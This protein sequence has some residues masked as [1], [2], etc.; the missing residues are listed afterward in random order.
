MEKVSDE[1][2]RQKEVKAFDEARTGVKGIVD[3]GS[4]TVPRMFIRPKDELSKE[5]E[6]PCV[7]DLQIP[8]ISLQGIDNKD[9]CDEIVKQV[10]YASEKWGFFQVVDHGIPFQVLEKMLQGNKM[11]HELDVEVKKVFYSRD[12]MKSVSYG[13]N[14]DLYNSRVANW[15]DTVA[16]VNSY[17][18]FFDPS[19]IPKLCRDAMMDYIEQILKLSDILLELLSMGLG[20]E[21][22]YLKEEMECNKGW[23]LVNHYYPPCPAP[24]LT[25][26]TSK[27]SDPAFLTILLQDQIGGLQVLYENQ[28]VNVNPIPD[29]FVVNIGDILQMISNDKLKSTYHRVTANLVGPRISTAFFLEGDQSSTKLYRPIKELVSEDHPCAYKDFTLRDFDTQ[30][31]NRPLNVPTFDLLKLENHAIVD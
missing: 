4:K 3:S 30:F 29:A 13:V 1:Y 7:D 15:R 25:L 5:H 14:Y 19:D 11:F 20:L 10:L 12:L 21:P 23:Y 24:E 18:G 28:W 9:V 2:D 17:P 27:H 8:V 31:R 6:I 16:I 26:A 22:S